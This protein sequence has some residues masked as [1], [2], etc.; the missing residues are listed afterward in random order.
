MELA[1][2]EGVDQVQE[3]DSVEEERP[4]DFGEERAPAQDQAG[5]VSAPV[6]GQGPFIR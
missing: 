1:L 6:A 3:G 5:T 4:E 2:Q